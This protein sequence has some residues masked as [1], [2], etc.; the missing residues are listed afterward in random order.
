MG[1]IYRQFYN[2]CDFHTLK[3]LYISLIR[4]RLEYA[5]Q[6][7]DPYYDIHI[8]RLERVQKFA[9]KIICKSWNESYASLCLKSNLL[10]LK[11]RRSFLKLLTFFRFVMSVHYIPPGILVTPGRRS[12]RLNHTN[13]FVV[14]YGRTLSFKSSFYHPLFYYGTVYHNLW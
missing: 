3:K 14:P 8:C 5:C 2:V 1:F 13:S 9:L 6:L 10:S 12:T 4:P 7:F 11:D